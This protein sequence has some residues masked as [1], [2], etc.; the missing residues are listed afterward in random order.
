MIFFY[1]FADIFVFGDEVAP[2][3]TMR[4]GAVTLLR[5][6]YYK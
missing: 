2:I 4:F 1:V 3:D 5:D 6:S